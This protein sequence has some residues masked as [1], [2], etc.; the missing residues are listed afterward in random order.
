MCC[1]QIAFVTLLQREE[2]PPSS[3]SLTDEEDSEQ[4]YKK[5]DKKKVKSKL[6]SMKDAEEEED[7]ESKRPSWTYNPAGVRRDHSVLSD[8]SDH[9]IGDAVYSPKLTIGDKADGNDD[10]AEANSTSRDIAA[11]I[12]LPETLH[13]YH[14]IRPPAIT[15]SGTWESDDVFIQDTD[16]KNG[17]AEENSEKLATK[18]EVIEENTSNLCQWQRDYFS[19]CKTGYQDRAHDLTPASSPCPLSLS[20]DGKMGCASKGEK[21]DRH[22]D[23]LSILVAAADS[24]ER[25]ES[26]DSKVCRNSAREVKV[27]HCSQWSLM[28][29]IDVDENGNTSEGMNEKMVSKKKSI[30]SSKPRTHLWYPAVGEPPLKVTVTDVTC[31][32]VRVTFVESPT[33]RGFFKNSCNT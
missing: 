14:G 15:T 30:F 8:Y 3:A 9:A 13:S 10:N 19:Y 11:G 20:P 18:T 27:N 24:I 2:S 4:D 12:L 29:T 22:M 28:K 1:F 7:C 17:N 6:D 5:A 21:V 16:V 31:N 25:R 23:N 32:C 33:E 26:D